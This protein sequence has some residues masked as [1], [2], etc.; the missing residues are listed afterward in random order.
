MKLFL[1][2]MVSKA[3]KICTSRYPTHSPNITKRFN[4][5]RPLP[6]N[7]DTFIH[8]A[9]RFLSTIIPNASPLYYLIWK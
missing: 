9:Y 3:K 4:V 2:R 1:R 6:E 7:S 8:D 5:I